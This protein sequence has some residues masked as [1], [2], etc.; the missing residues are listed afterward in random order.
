MS[1]LQIMFVGSKE[2]A[3][4]KLYRNSVAGRSCRCLDYELFQRGSKMCISGRMR[5]IERWKPFHAN[6]P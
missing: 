6:T 5:G 3:T 2:F 1:T 4:R